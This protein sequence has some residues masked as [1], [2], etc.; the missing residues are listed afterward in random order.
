MSEFNLSK[1]IRTAGTGSQWEV[2]GAVDVKEFIRLLKEFMQGNSEK[3]PVIMGKYGIRRYP[4]REIDKLAG[5]K[6]T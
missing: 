2:I 4:I 1:K 5:E 6:L 3:E